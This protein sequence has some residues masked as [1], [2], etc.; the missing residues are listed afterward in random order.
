MT[1]DT[2]RRAD[3]LAQLSLTWPSR[4]AAVA[5]AMH[6]APPLNPATLDRLVTVYRAGRKAVA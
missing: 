4:A 1:A 3:E 6:A 5:A 2:S